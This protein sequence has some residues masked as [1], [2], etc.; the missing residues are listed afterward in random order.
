MK[1][2]MKQS[3]LSYVEEVAAGDTFLWDSKHYLV[4]ADESKPGVTLAVNLDSG[5]VTAF[6]H[7]TPVLQTRLYA[8]GEIVRPC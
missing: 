4:M 7:D 1:V 6:S 3:N 5:E 8:T 2:E